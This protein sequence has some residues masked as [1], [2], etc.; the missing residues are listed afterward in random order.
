MVQRLEAAEVPVDL[1][2]V[3]GQN[4]GLALL[5]ADVRRAMQSFLD[6]NL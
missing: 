1:V 4:H 3:D 2:V 5:N 6:G